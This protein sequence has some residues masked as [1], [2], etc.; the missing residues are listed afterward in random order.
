MKS[1]SPPREM[2]PT[3]APLSLHVDQ[4]LMWRYVIG[5]PVARV[6]INSWRTVYQ[7][8]QFL[9]DDPIWSQEVCHGVS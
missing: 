9:A 1:T 4:Q 5:D 2:R 7:V 8:T 6:A 3:S